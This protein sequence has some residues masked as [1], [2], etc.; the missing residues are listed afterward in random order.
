MKRAL[1]LLLIAFFVLAAVG[2]GSSEDASSAAPGATAP[3]T[4]ASATT[5]PAA[6]AGRT[7]YCD[8]SGTGLGQCIEYPLSEA[9]SEDA[10]REQ[11]T[12]IEGTLSDTPCPTEGR[13][14]TC[15]PNLGNNVRYY[16]GTQNQYTADTASQ[17]CS[18][19]RNGNW[20]AGS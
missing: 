7:M 5:A 3:A 18:M 20:T 12:S 2:S 14:G 15:R 11:C 9:T 10:V 13:I 8:A 4:P 17:E 1:S 19:L 6:P 16:Y